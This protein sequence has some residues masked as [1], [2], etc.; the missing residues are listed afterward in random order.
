VIY[1]FYHCI[2]S[3]SSLEIRVLSNSLELSISYVGRI[4][5]LLEDFWRMPFLR[6]ESMW[7]RLEQGKGDFGGKEM[8]YMHFT[9]KK[10]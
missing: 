5:G 6:K 10:A 1:S 8:S 7:V 3:P 2:L 4:V 9:G